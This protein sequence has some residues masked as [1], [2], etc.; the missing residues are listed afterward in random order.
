MECLTTVKA[1]DPIEPLMSLIIILFALPF[2]S[3]LFLFLCRC[4][5]AVV[6][7]PLLL[8]TYS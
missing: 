7:A 3:F 6:D 8:L 4:V 2:S 5:S 1:A